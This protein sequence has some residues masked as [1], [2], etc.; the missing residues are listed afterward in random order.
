MLGTAGDRR[1]DELLA[2]CYDRALWLLDGRPA[3]GRG[4]ARDRGS[5]SRLRSAAAPRS[6]WR[7]TT[8]R[9]VLE[10]VRDDDVAAPGLR[11]A[12]LGALW[13]LEVADDDAL[14]AGPAQFAD[15]EQ[16]GRLPLRP[17]HA[18][19]RAG[20]ARPDLVQRIDELVMAFADGE[21]LDALPALRRAFSVFTPRERD[22]LAR[23]LP[24]A[25]ARAWSTA[26]VA[27]ETLAA[28]LAL[29]ARLRAALERY[30]VRT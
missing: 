23:S 17:V 27:P 7:A 29:E 28:M 26:T 20:A 4:R 18:R 16:L 19:P 2:A 21:F 5:P 14:V 10:R 22:R 1:T 6:A 8:W 11:G 3:R 15:P 13:A 25:S 12:A 24:G 30:G 9:G